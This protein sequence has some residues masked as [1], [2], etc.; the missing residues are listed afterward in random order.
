MSIYS[1]LSDMELTGLLR[2]GNRAAFSEIY[3]RYWDGLY[4]HCLKML[5]DESEAQDLV[6]ELFISLWEKSNELDLKINVAGYLY[7]T[8]RH[9]VLNAIRKRRNYDKFIDALSDYIVVM[10]DTILDQISEKE[11]AA[12]IDNEIQHLPDKMKEVFICSRRDYLSHREIAER[13]GISD[14][15]VKKQVANAIRILRLKIGA[16]EVLVLMVYF[17]SK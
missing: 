13:L 2:S 16:Y 10:D 4:I 8:A 3:N 6:Q 1:K 12:A 11:L 9:R 5:K 7:V 14:K 15:T 17:Y